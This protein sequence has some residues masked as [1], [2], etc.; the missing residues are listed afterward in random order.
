MQK[1]DT[2][3]GV[4]AGYEDVWRERYC[5]LRLEITLLY[6]HLRR[7]KRVP[8][9]H[10][11]RWRYMGALFH[12][13]N[14]KKL[15]CSGNIQIPREPKALN[16]SSAGKIVISVF[17]DAEEFVQFVFML[18]GTIINAEAYWGTLRRL[19]KLFTVG[20]LSRCVNLQHE[21]TIP[22]QYLSD[23]RAVA[24]VSRGISG[25]STL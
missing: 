23:T 9:V 15:E 20:R 2:A 16:C 4:H 18:W 17:W 14:Q 11:D 24:I 5:N 7:R 21:N 22:T 10:S 25:Q 3:K 1:W 13:S 12:S 6:L 8:G 19:V